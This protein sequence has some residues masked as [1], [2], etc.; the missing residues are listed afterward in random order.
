[1]KMTH[2]WLGSEK[3]WRMWCNNCG[4][5]NYKNVVYTFIVRF[6]KQ[7][8]NKTMSSTSAACKTESV[9]CSIC[10]NALTV[11]ASL[12]TLSCGHKFHLQCLICNVKA[13]N[14]ECPLCR[15]IIDDSLI[16]MLA[17]SNQSIVM[18]SFIWKDSDQS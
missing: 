16:K 10:L 5:K 18:V 2:S 9:D 7:S 6:L 13:Q 12:L 4:M 8:H 11:G 1:M 17:A 14:K 15:A 3:R